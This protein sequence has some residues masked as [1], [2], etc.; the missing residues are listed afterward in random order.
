MSSEE[1]RFQR[2]G[3]RLEEIQPLNLSIVYAL[4][5]MDFADNDASELAS[6]V[7]DGFE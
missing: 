5:L 1:S 7:A 2:V 3:R 4:G 6:S